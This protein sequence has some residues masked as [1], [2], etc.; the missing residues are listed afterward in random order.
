MVAVRTAGCPLLWKDVANSSSGENCGGLLAKV[1]DAT[2]EIVHVA[3]SLYSLP[4]PFADGAAQRTGNFVKNGAIVGR[5]NGD[6]ESPGSL[7]Q[8]TATGIRVIRWRVFT[9]AAWPGHR[10]RDGSG[11]A[12][13]QRTTLAN[14]FGIKRY[15]ESSVTFCARY[16]RT[17]TDHHH[18]PD[19]DARDMLGHPEQYR[20]IP[21]TRFG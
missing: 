8:K 5:E 13:A 12:V 4:T 20:A 1:W 16:A 7:G 15:L 17:N 21:S 6:R 3:T 18:P 11:W 9:R 19:R 10:V 14:R 2:D